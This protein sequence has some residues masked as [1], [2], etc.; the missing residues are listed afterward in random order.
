M[1]QPSQAQTQQADD[2][3]S[4]KVKITY[5]EYV[6]LSVMITDCVKQYERDEGVDSVQQ[7][8]IVNRLVERLEV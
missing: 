7:A 4:K 3:K 5:D 1:K 6:K 2:A 8:E